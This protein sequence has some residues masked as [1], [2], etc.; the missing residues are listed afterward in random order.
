MTAVN[1]RAALYFF[2][3][4]DIMDDLKQDLAKSKIQKYPAVVL[5]R[6]RGRCCLEWHMTGAISRSPS[7]H[8]RFAD[9]AG[10]NDQLGALQCCPRLR[11]EHSM[12]IGDDDRQC[13]GFMR[14]A[15]VSQSVTTP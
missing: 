6:R 4:G 3:I 13:P 10:V 7:Q 15:S 12:G 9:V 1:G 8:L 11:T 5:P 2:H 14:L